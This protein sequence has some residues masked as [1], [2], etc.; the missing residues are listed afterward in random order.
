MARRAARSAPLALADRASRR[1]WR[2]SSIAAVAALPRLGPGE[3]PGARRLAPA[4]AGSAATRRAVDRR[5]RG[6]RA[7]PALGATAGVIAGSIGYWVFD[8]AVLWATFHAFG[9]SPPLTVILMGYLIGQLGGLLPIPGGIGGI[10]LGLIGD[11]GRL[12]RPRG[13][14]RGGRARLPDHPLL[15]AA[16]RRRHRLRDAAPRHAEWPGVRRLRAGDRR[17]VRASPGLGASAL[18]P[19]RTGQRHAVAE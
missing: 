10:D 19:P 12:R 6:G 9:V 18:W 17:A 14:H 3:P 8:N 11:A 7:D 4:R 13:G 1:R 5:H 16:A 15:A 2:R